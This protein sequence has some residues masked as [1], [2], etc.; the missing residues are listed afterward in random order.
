MRWC[1]NTNSLRER[2]TDRS[3]QSLES[4]GLCVG[5]SAL[6]ESLE[7]S[8]Q[9]STYW[10]MIHRRKLADRLNPENLLFQTHWLVL[11]LNV[12]NPVIPSQ[13]PS[14]SVP[15]VSPEGVI[16]TFSHTS[17]TLSLFSDTCLEEDIGLSLYK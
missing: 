12:R 4:V 8:K 11:H 13:R 6:E 17:V 16:W 1:W 9:S 14:C 5:P 3:I 10:R 7:A 2:G 15:F